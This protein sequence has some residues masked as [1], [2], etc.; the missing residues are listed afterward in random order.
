MPPRDQ[1]ASALARFQQRREQTARALLEAARRVLAFKGYHD[2]KVVDIARAANVGVGTFYLYYPTK[3]AIFLQLVQDT[4]Q[5][6][7]REL[8]DAR[9]KEADPVVRARLGYEIF[10][11][12][13]Q[14]NRELFRIVFGH[15]AAFNQV[16][17]QAQGMFVHDLVQ[18]LE[19]GMRIGVFRPNRTDVLAQASIGMSL[20]V[21]SWWLDQKDMPIE[22]VIAALL[23]FAFHGVAAD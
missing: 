21:V 8:D 20:Q 16:L 23:D 5:R 3:Q 4:A 13:A 12:F 6:L 15:G 11:R 1:P 22:D 2:T 7:K 18:N 19:E 17:R 9:A 14:D 10:F